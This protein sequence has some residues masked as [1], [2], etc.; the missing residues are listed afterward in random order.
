VFF[1]AISIRS[2]KLP[3]Q[4]PNSHVVEITGGLLSMATGATSLGR[5]GVSPAHV[6][7][8]EFF[9]LEVVALHFALGGGSPLA[10]FP[11]CS[12]S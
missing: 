2:N 5:D 3:W 10:D 11:Y 7:R 1:E 9:P 12:N 4:Q 6:F 8:F